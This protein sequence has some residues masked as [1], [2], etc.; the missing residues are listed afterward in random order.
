M[1]P[2][3]PKR[4]RATALA[5][6]AMGGCAHPGPREGVI[7]RPAVLAPGNPAPR[8]PAERLATRDTAIV[9]IQ[10]V[11]DT[12]G[13]AD[14]S[15]VKVLGSPLPAFTRAAL[16]ALPTYRFLPAEVGGGAPRGCRPAPSGVPQCSIP[17]RPGKK[18]RQLL[19]IPFR[20]QPPAS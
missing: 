14:M 2:A 9:R 12:S 1:P 18:V 16:E 13:Y 19:E 11:V 17:G 15:T 20:F 10:V 6:G 5:I 8:Y 3:F 7:E 4:L